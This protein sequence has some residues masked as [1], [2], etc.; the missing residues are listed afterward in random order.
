LDNTS[1]TFYLKQTGTYNASTDPGGCISGSNLA[2]QAQ[3]HESGSVQGHW[4]NYNNAQN[5]SSNNLGNV[6]EAQ[7]GVPSLTSQDFVTQVNNALTSA[8]Q[9][10]LTATQVEPYPVY[11][12]Q[13]GT[14]LGYINYA[15]SYTSC[16]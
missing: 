10:I 8:Q 3:R 16:H 12:D 9:A 15:P 1:S 7:I 4:G 2:S 13:N 11:D 14:F 5:G 6:A